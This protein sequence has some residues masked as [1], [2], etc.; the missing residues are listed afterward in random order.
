[1]SIEAFFGLIAL[2]ESNV[3]KCNRLLP[4]I[5]GLILQL[6]SNSCAGQKIEVRAE[7]IDHQ[8]SLPFG[9]LVVSDTTHLFIAGAIAE[10][11]K[12]SVTIDTPG[13]YRFTF[14]AIGFVS[15]DT[16]VH[17]QSSIDLGS[18]L[19]LPAPSEMREVN[20]VAQ[21]PLFEKTSEGTKMNVGQTMLSKSMNATE[22]IT[23]TPGISIVSGKVNVNGRGEAVLIINGKET[24]LESFKSIPAGDLESVEV[25]TNPDARYDAKGK[26][27]VIVTLKKD[28]RQGYSVNLTNSTTLSMVKGAEITR[29]VLHAPN[30]AINFRKDKW[31]F[32]GY[33]GN[34]YGLNWSENVYNT[35]IAAS[36]GQYITNGY[37]QEDNFSKGVH[38]YK[39]GAG[40]TINK[41]SEISFQYDGMHHYFELDVRQNGDYTNPQN[42]LTQLRMQNDAT[43][44][45]SNHSLNLNYSLRTDTLGSSLFA[46]AQFNRFENKLLDQITERIGTNSSDQTVYN[47]INDGL[48]VIQLSTIQLDYVKKYRSQTWEAGFKYGQATNDGEIHFYSK[49]FDQPDY[50]ENLSIANS[51]TYTEEI[52]AVYIN[53]KSSHKNWKFQAGLRAEYTFVES[54]SNR[55]N[56]AILDTSYLNIFPSA[57]INYALSSNSFVGLNYS[58]K[59]NRPVYQDLDPFL[60]YLDSLTSIQGNPALKPEYLHQMELRLGYQS[61][62]LRGAYTISEQTIWAITAAGY[63]GENSVRYIKE[64]LQHRYTTTLAL[65]APFEMGNYSS[66]NSIALNAYRFNDNR[67][68]FKTG[69]IRPQFYLYSFHQFVVKNWFTIDGLFE[70]YGSSSDGFTKRSPY[71]YGTIGLSKSFWKEALQVQLNFNDIARTARFK[72]IRTINTYTNDYNQRFNTHYLRLTVTYNF[73]KLKAF[74]YQNKSVN[75]T[76]FNR[77][78]R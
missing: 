74:N 66:Y 29:Y 58:R 17:L 71:Y 33:Y 63:S 69:R 10:E 28:A 59:I 57:R 39:A 45:L 49:L 78:K 9:Q 16:V 41:Q 6:I 26:A 72:G 67:P 23:R 8:G 73:S 20:V 56:T 15:K 37:Y 75:E 34:E 48:N 54:K 38:Y 51:T 31:N 14:S 1:M 55:Y 2:H 61:F 62:V 46:A 13:V 30:C 50:T 21:K 35:F 11:G 42:E 5:S 36:S 32:T 44:T 53:F 76:E 3:M 43:T 22:V 65:D 52:P 12:L 25:L 70:Y 60:W 19:L 7:I 77:I 68:E 4:I 64:N 27:V 40:Y 47:R 18:F 24:T